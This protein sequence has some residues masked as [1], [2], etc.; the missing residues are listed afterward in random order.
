MGSERDVERL[1]ELAV[2]ARKGDLASFEELV[3]R[4]HVDTYTLA[5]RLMGNGEDAAD[6]TQEA[7][8]RAWKGIRKFRG[9]ARFSTWMYRITAN[10]A[11]NH[12]DKRR[13]T[14]TENLD[15][16][17]EPVDLDPDRQPELVAEASSGM[18]SLSAALEHIPPK[19]RTVVVLKDVYDLTHDEIAD[20]LDI[21]V[22]AAKVR[23]HRGRKQL[24]ELI[25]AEDDGQAY[26]V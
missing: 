5:M 11:S 8:V 26:A 1:E 12:L 18:D 15:D 19:L 6:V 10:T 14:R 17:A 9:D 3:R 21:S 20:E 13:R 24:R 7:Y 22:T 25:D 23:L 4:T 16:L 2:D